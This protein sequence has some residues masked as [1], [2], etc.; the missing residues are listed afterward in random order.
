MVEY[1]AQYMMR[2]GMISAL[3]VQAYQEAAAVSGRGR[4]GRAGGDGK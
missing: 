1:V 4:Q 3:D 2:K